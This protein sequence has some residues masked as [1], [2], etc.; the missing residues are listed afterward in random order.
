MF[1]VCLVMLVIVCGSGLCVFY[2]LIW[3]VSVL[4]CGWVW[5]IFISGVF[6]MI[7]LF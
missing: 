4:W 7:L 2:R 5:S 1:F 6:D 3:N